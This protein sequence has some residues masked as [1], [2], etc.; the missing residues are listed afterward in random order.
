MRAWQTKKE[1]I[2]MKEWLLAVALWIGML[3]SC[4]SLIGVADWVEIRFTCIML[5]SGILL[6]LYW[7]VRKSK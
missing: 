6:I 1:E 7:W 2:I 5:I 3:I 4:K